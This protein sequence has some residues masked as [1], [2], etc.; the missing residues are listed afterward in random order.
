L[1]DGNETK[2][3]AGKLVAEING[4]GEIEER[5]HDRVLGSGAGR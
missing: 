1:G 4:K 3:P 2:E 5:E